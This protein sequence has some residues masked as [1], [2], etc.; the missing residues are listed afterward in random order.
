MSEETYEVRKA[1]EAEVF[2]RLYDTTRSMTT[3]FSDDA[4]RTLYL[5]LV[6]KARG[7]HEDSTEPGMNMEGAM[8]SMGIVGCVYEIK[9]RMDNGTW[10]IQREV[11]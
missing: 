3:E 10:D 7:L 6:K 11:E 1:R 5:N 2:G 9:R 4:L 8:A